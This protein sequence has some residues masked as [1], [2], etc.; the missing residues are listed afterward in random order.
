NLISLLTDG[1]HGGV[2]FTDEGVLFLRNTN[3]KAG[4]IDLNDKR[5]ISHEESAETLRAELTEGDILLT[6]IG[7]LIGESVVIP[8][9]FPKATINQNLGVCKINCVS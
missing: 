7:S 2:D 3:V 5:Y 6:T 4:V 1:K 9:G 8:K